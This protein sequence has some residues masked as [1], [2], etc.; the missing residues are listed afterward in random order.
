MIKWVCPN[1]MCD[2]AVDRPDRDELGRRVC[3]RCRR[4]EENKGEGIG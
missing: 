2:V 4:I 3:P 1:P